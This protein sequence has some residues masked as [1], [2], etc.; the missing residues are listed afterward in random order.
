MSVK[1][2]VEANSSV[3][4]ENEF[5]TVKNNIENSLRY[6]SKRSIDL[7]DALLIDDMSEI[8]SKLSS[9]LNGLGGFVGVQDSITGSF[10]SIPEDM[11]P[12]LDSLVKESEDLVKFIRSSEV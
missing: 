10:P 3:K 11:K 12:Q 7:S 6:I 2:I 9:V 8:C 5:R 4:Y 1:R